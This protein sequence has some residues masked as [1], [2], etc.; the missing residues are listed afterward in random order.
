MT[1]AVRMIV[2]AGQEPPSEALPFGS[3]LLDIDRII[4]LRRIPPLS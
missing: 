2:T 3:F 4:Y 1:E